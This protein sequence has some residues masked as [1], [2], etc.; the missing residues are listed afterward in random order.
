MPD[1]V[2]LTDHSSG[3]GSRAALGEAVERLTGESAIAIDARHFMSGGTGR[4]WLERGRLTLAV[5]CDDLM[6]RPAIVVIYEIPP[7]ERRGF[8]AFQRRL[9]A[10]GAVS[11]GTDSRAWRDATE[12]NR[13]VERLRREGVPQMETVSLGAPSAAQASRAFKRL[14]SNVWAR[15]TVGAGGQGVFHITTED[16]LAVA[17]SNYERTGERWL[18]ARDARNFNEDGRRHQFRAVVLGDRVLRACEHVQDDPDAPC[19]ESRGAVST[20]LA[21]D[22]M[23]AELRRTAVSA[24]RTLGLPFSGVDLATSSGGVVFEVNV[25]PVICAPRGL[26]D[27]AIPYVEAHLA[28]LRP[29]PL[30]VGL[31]HPAR[32]GGAATR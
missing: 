25:H 16:E 1:V 8:E 13:A 4:A 27:V 22:E 7:A 11:L 19:N 5:D 24:T 2:L 14:G 17:R 10:C 18:I 23:P 28:L 15:P 31:A 3:E 9:R 6:V 30:R 21:V 20:L 29:R 32:D 12:K 26:E